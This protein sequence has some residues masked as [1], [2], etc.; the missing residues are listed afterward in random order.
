MS[1][2]FTVLATT[3]DNEELF[4]IDALTY[5]LREVGVL[6]GGEFIASGDD[7]MFCCKH[8]EKGELTGWRISAKKNSDNM[9]VEALITNELAKKYNFSMMV[10]N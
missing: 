4:G 2:G 5:F 9:Q 1:K 10:L 8:D 7:V 3:S 6:T